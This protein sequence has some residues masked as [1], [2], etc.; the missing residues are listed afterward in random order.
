MGKLL[1]SHRYRNKSNNWLA[2]AYVDVARTGKPCAIVQWKS[3]TVFPIRRSIFF[4]RTQIYTNIWR[5]PPWNNNIS[6]TIDTH[7]PR[8]W[9]G[10]FVWAI[11]NMFSYL[12]YEKHS[13]GPVIC[14]KC[15]TKIPLYTH[16]LHLGNI[17]HALKS[18]VT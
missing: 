17:S 4:N 2:S 10:Y 3:H 8:P 1:C 9:H 12:T 15:L 5:F 14:V 16:K 13:S 7:A 6:V 11:Y 18:Q